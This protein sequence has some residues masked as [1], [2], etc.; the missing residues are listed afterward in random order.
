MCMLIF[1]LGVNFFQGLAD[2]LIKALLELLTVR[3]TAI[4]EQAI[5][6]F[7]LPSF[8]RHYFPKF[9]DFGSW[10]MQSK[11]KYVFFLFTLLI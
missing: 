11:I 7:E 4:L 6:A 1:H 2:Q 10:N 8:E 5:D 3:A 9:A